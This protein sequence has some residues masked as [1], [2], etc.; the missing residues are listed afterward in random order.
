MAVRE[1]VANAIRRRVRRE[2]DQAIAGLDAIVAA[3]HERVRV[4]HDGADDAVE[5]SSQLLQRPP[6]ESDWDVELEDPTGAALDEREQPCRAA[7]NLMEHRGH[8]RATGRDRD[9]DAD[10]FE[11]PEVGALADARDDAS[12][13]ELAGE[14]GCQQVPLVVVDDADQHIAA[15]DV[16]LLQQLEIRTIAV[17]DQGM[18]QPSGNHLAARRVVLDQNQVN[19]VVLSIQALSKL[20]PDVAAA[21]DSDMLSPGIGG[22]GYARAN[23]PERVRHTH[24]NGPVPRSQL[25]RTPRDEELFASSHSHDQRTV[26]QVQISDTTAGKERVGIDSVFNELNRP[27]GER[28][29]IERPGD[30]HDALHVFG[31]L[32]L[33]PDHPI[34]AKGC[35]AAAFRRIQGEVLARHE[36]DR[37]CLS[38][39]PRHGTSDDIDLVQ[40][41]A[42]Y[43]NVGA[44]DLRAGQHVRAGT[45]AQNELHVQAF[46]SVGNLRGMVYD[47]N[48]VLDRQRLRQRKPNL[49]ATDDD[50]AHWC[51]IVLSRRA[52]PAN[53][54]ADTLAKRRLKP[55]RK[56]CVGPHKGYVVDCGRIGVPYQ[57]N[58]VKSR[59]TRV[60]CQ[61]LVLL[62]VV[63]L[64]ASVVAAQ[65]VN[66]KPGRYEVSVEMEMA[67]SPTKMPPMKDTQCITAEDLKDFSR[68]L[69][70]SEERER[71]K[72]SDYRATGSKVTFNATCVEDGETYKMDAEMMFA[73]DSFTGMM[74]SNHK[75]QA[76]TIK[77]VAK[78]TGACVK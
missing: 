36:T 5:R 58:P 39:L 18:A 4:P 1:I 78:R 28:L 44:I 74:R 38:Q 15:S 13:A 65:A 46:E 30:T 2:N 42:G 41:S 40:A 69:V 56:R 34:D 53:S 75:G 14:E 52:E 19:R 24:H 55:P 23:L 70:D 73:G 50:A 60:L 61:L 31:E 26:R 20:K 66:L 54:R 57:N 71:C 68:L 76:M 32:R 62:G 16:L 3:R 37:A 29:R 27:I 47:E 77:S 48:V 9:I 63:A 11:Q 43:E 35:K 45:V 51:E 21:D 6:P 64:T 67:N 7:L 17:D 72:I 8:R 10:T 22:A 33:G 25:A 49:S 59:S 12:N